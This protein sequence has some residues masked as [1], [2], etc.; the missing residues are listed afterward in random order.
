MREILFRGKRIDNNEWVYG[1]YFCMV[2]DDG[3][4]AHHFI[5]PLG[6]DLSLGTPIEKIQVE[7]D[8]KTIGQYTGLTD[9][10]G[11]KIFEGDIVE[12]VYDGNMNIRLIIWDNDELDFK[13]TNGKEHYKTNFDYLPCCEELVIIGKIFD[14]PELL[15]G[16]DLS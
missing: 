14:N 2:H 9:K 5:I 13:G 8:H 4:H 7:V 16:V 12:C 1:Y 15:K 11:M 10:N 6:V 3:R